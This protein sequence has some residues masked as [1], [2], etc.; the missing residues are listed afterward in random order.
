MP[1]PQ[2]SNKYQSTHCGKCTKGVVA[3]A[4]REYNEDFNWGGRGSE[5]PS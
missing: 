4:M 5:K 3:G 1:H 2:Y